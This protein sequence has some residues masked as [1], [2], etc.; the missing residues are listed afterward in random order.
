MTPNAA[1][2]TLDVTATIRG[3]VATLH[4]FA[5]GADN[6]FAGTEILAVFL[7]QLGSRRGKEW[8]RGSYYPL[9]DLLFV[10]A[11][12]LPA[13][14]IQ[15][16][17]GG[18]R[19][20]VIDSSDLQRLR[21]SIPA[22]ELTSLAA[23]QRDLVHAAQQCN[24]GQ[25]IVS[26]GCTRDAI[27]SLVQASP[28]DNTL[29]VAKSQAAAEQ[30]AKWLRPRCRQHVSTGPKVPWNLRPLVHAD[31]LSGL[32]RSAH[33]WPTLVF[34]DV[35]S[36]RSTT[37][38]QLAASMSDSRI[39]AV[40]TPDQKLD[41]EDTLRLRITCG[42]EIYRIDGKPFTGTKVT[43]LLIRALRSR[44][45]LLS[46]PLKNKRRQWW[47]N[48]KLNQQIASLAESFSNM[49]LPALHAL[50]IPLQ[51]IDKQRT[52][53]GERPRVA[54][55]VE[56]SEHAR[57]LRRVLPGWPIRDGR[58]LTSRAYPTLPLDHQRVIVT[59]ARALAAGLA[60]DLVIRAD[61]T[62]V[63]WRDDFGPHYGFNGGTMLIV[64]LQGAFD[65]LSRR[66]SASRL[67]DYRSRGWEVVCC[68]SADAGESSDGLPTVAA[69]GTNS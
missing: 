4:A 38:M 16:R 25:I 40:R 51:T 36:A 68:E 50:G 19:V 45:K 13:I 42:P 66:R 48:A 41:W 22:S 62:G 39:Y 33:D 64:D 57:V 3:D 27:A 29:I 8:G 30:I 67:D 10:H 1:P 26:A 32:D 46:C 31:S 21:S 12:D 35:E 2:N 14:A 9:Q 69:A 58:R 43:V 56:S 37:G 44:K 11:A 23:W 18:H 52:K 65:R 47:R 54:I 24:Q 53:T 15:L 55:L 59:H 63:D 7:E 6:L 17:A 61:G 49:D 20:E 5:I 34:A 28:Q 60:A